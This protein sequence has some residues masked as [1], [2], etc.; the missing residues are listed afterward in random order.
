MVCVSVY[1]HSKHGPNSTTQN[2]FGWH[3]ITGL[4]YEL[5]MLC[6]LCLRMNIKLN[7]DGFLVFLS[8]LIF[9]Y[10]RTNIDI[11][12]LVAE[13]VCVFIFIL[14]PAIVV[15]VSKI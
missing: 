13:Y 15:K 11:F 10:C 5:S 7:L 1:M 4:C 8:Y 14:S 9:V 6:R 2:R 12:I 3:Y